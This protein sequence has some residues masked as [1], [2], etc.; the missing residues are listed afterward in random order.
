M[1]AP[2]LV[3]VSRAE[4]IHVRRRAQE[5]HDFDGLMSR[6]V[7]PQADGVVGHH[8]DHPEARKGA[9]ISVIIR[10]LVKTENKKRTEHT[11]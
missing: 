6:P 7:F 2:Y 8:V 9:V 1:V 4:G 11:V 3:S 5:F 10:V